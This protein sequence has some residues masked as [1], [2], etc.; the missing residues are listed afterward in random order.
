MKKFLI[1]LACAAVIT[2]AF[3]DEIPKI[4][5][6][7]TYEGNLQL[8]SVDTREFTISKIVVNQRCEV[9]QT[10]VSIRDE[11]K[12]GCGTTG[13]EG[14]DNLARDYMVSYAK[15][16]CAA[17]GK[18]CDIEK[19]R[20]GEKPLPGKAFAECATPKMIHMGDNITINPTSLNCGTV[21]NLDVETSLGSIHWPA[22]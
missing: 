21:V 6:S 10:T 2:P 13:K 22:E 5:L 4:T 3:A 19:S 17:I 16:V 1:A 7:E 18:G 12:A 11:T 14:A 8:T 15:A 20:P 9:P